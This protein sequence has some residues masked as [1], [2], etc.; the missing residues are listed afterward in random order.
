VNL[1]LLSPCH[2][3][4]LRRL[5]LPP[6]SSRPSPAVISNAVR[7]LMQ[8]SS[9][10][11]K[12]SSGTRDFSLRF[13]MTEGGGISTIALPGMTSFR[14]S[15]T[16]LATFL[17]YHRGLP[18]PSPRL[19]CTVLSTYPRCHLDQRERSHAAIIRLKEGIL[20]NT[21]FLASLRNDRGGGIS[22]IAL[23]GMTSFRPS[24]TILATFL[25]YPRDLPALSSRPSCTVAS[26]F[27]RCPLDIPPL[28]SRTQ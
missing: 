14:P 20:G 6:L 25:H 1:D 26:T 15:C 16:I 24:C 17:H 21:R 27:P 18:A 23:P 3:F 28:S 11:R 13:E 5:D 12:V 8:P 22:T 9:T 2:P 4:L 7:D 10:P 19:S